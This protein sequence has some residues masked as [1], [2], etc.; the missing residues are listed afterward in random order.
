[1]QQPGIALKV[2]TQISFLMYN[3]IEIINSSII[4]SA[5]KIKAGN[6]IVENQYPVRIQVKAIF[7]YPGKGHILSAFLLKKEQNVI[8]L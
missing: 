7:S 5:A 3:S 1:M 8:P 6:F 4:V 2:G